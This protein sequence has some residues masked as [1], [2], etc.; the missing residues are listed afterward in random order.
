MSLLSSIVGAV[1][2]GASSGDKTQTSS[3]APWGPAQGWITDNIGSGQA[4]QRQ[5][6]QNP[7]S[8]LQLD[9]YANQFG[10]TRD[11]RGQMGSLQDQMNRQR[12]FNRS[13]PLTRPNQYQFG[14]QAAGMVAGGASGGPTTLPS[15]GFDTN[16]F[17][18]F[19]ASPAAPVAMN[20]GGYALGDA[21]GNDLA[22][23][24]SG[25]FVDP[26][27]SMGGLGLYGGGATAFHQGIQGVMNGPLG[28]AIGTIANA[29]GGRQNAPSV[30]HGDAYG[31]SVAAMRDAEMRA[32]MDA[33]AA[34]FG[35][36][37]LGGLGGDSFGGAGNFGGGAYGDGEGR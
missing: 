12:Q 20:P 9:A 19:S 8:P 28:I 30:P 37:G 23:S 24:R 5:Y 21:P 33:D 17:A 29:L 25:G 18:A 10:A 3:S 22:P 2:G 26:F 7:F 35:N 6:Q 32:A 14:P 27:G 4:L 1:L 36:G 13:E 16:P 11:F 15:Y 31:V 34:Q